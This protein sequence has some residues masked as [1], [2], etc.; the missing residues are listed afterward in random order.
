MHQSVK[1]RIIRLLKSVQGKPIPQSY[2][3]R[4]VNASKSRVSEVLSELEK[5]GLIYRY[6]IGRSKIIYVNES[7]LTEKREEP[8]STTRTLKLGIVYSSEY[9]FLGYF[10]KNLLRY[11]INVEVVVF[12]DGLEATKMLANGGIDLA[13]SPLVGQLYLYPTYRTYRIVLNGLYGG[14]RVLYK[15]GESAVY[16]SMISTMDYIRYYI[17]KNKLI[18]ARETRYFRNKSDVRALA[19]KGG[20]FVLWHP[21]YKE[22]ENAGF[23]PVL[24]PEDV[25]VNFCCTLAISNTVGE[26]LFKIV[27]K[28][29][30]ESIAK[31]TKNPERYIEYYSAIVGINSSLLKSATKEY[32]PLES[33]SRIINK[34]VESK[35]LGV[36]SESAYLEAAEE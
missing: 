31:Y 30:S 23:K 8:S 36:P 25:Q 6:S 5:E 4:A 33:G 28:V 15:P 16:S 32:R 21:L 19:R 3:Y 22:L 10:V 1:E 13:L 18:D 11:G 34:V 29:Y 27:K 2:V 26:K 17:V 35:L 12:G 7:A 14:F 9:L 20:Y 24:G